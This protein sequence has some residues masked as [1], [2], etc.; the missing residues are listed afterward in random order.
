M[1]NTEY[2]KEVN[3]T[4]EYIIDYAT[5]SVEDET[6]EDAV[7]ELIND[8]LLHET[9][10]GHEWIIYTHNHLPILQYSDNAE[11]MADNIGGTEEA[12]K[13]GIDNLHQ[14]LAFWAFYADVQ[15][16]ISTQLEQ[17]EAA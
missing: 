6:D 15:E 4:A 7:E 10:D 9:I 8:S 3:D 14:A 13:Q 1:N 12:L 16:S 2:W 17:L 5:A 11:Y